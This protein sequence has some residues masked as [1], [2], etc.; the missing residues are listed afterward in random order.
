MIIFALLFSLNVSY[1]M[2]VPLKR[3]SVE[4]KAVYEKSYSKVPPKVK[5]PKNDNIKRIKRVAIIFG[6]IVLA[7]FILALRAVK[8]P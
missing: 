2:Q 7:I 6:T 3:D 1:A 8:T 4:Y 5:T